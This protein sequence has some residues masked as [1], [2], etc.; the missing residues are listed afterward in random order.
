MRRCL[1]LLA[2]LPLA[3]FAACGE[4]ADD[5][6]PAGTGGTASDPV[7]GGRESGGGTYLWGGNSSGGA[8]PG[9][10]QGPRL[11]ESLPPA[12]E[13]VAPEAVPEIRY[14]EDLRVRAER[15]VL[16][17]E[18]GVVDTG[19]QEVLWAD[20]EGRFRL[21]ALESLD[22]DDPQWDPVS[23]ELQME[24]EVRGGFLLR[25][26]D[27]H[28]GHPH[29]YT[30]NYDWY[31]DPQPH[32]VAGRA[33][34]LWAGRSR[35]AFG[36]VDLI[37]DDA[38]GL[39]LGWSLYDPGLVERASC[40]VKSVDLDPDLKGIVWQ[41]R[42]VASEEYD[43][44]LHQQRV[45]FTPIEPL[46]VPPGFYEKSQEVLASGPLLGVPHDLHVRVYHD[47]VQSL[48][49]VEQRAAGAVPGATEEPVTTV[50]HSRVAGIEMVEGRIDGVEIWIAGT[51]PAVELETIFGSLVR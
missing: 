28:L 41:Q 51:L 32:Q 23:P 8:A 15:E 25:F 14:L 37:V 39:L 50:R 12:A 49:V 9:P 34:T 30:T 6:V 2:A 31:R 5:V 13:Q 20:G 18:H 46:Y 26:R 17:Y 4:A 29:A 21:E 10:I 16:F 19:F 24:Y 47:G 27:P 42:A 45:G 33:C 3:A 11:K 38:S 43:P 44:Q 22:D 40:R 36:G 35:H 7:E 1:V 48:F